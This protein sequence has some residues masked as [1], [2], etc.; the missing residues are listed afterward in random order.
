MNI[1]KTGYYQLVL[2]D[3][4]GKEIQTILRETIVAGAYKKIVNMNNY[5]SGIYFLKFHGEK[6]NICQKIVF[7]K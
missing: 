2:Y 3:I 7:I 4:L 5:P 1:S 6:I